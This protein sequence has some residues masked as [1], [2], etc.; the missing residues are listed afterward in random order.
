MNRLIQHLL[1]VLLFAWLVPGAEGAVYRCPGPQ[2]HPLFQDHPCTGTAAPAAAPAPAATGGKHFLWR[3]EGKQ[4]SAWLLGSLHFGTPALYPL[5]APVTAAYEGS[6]ALV[7]EADILSG[8]GQSALLEVAQQGSYLDGTT[9]R[10]HL[11][12][13]TWNALER[14]TRRHQLPTELIALQ[15]PWL[16]ALTVLGVALRGA[17]F[18]ETLGI[19]RHFLQQARGR[20]PILELESVGG[21]M[22]L[23]ADFSEAEQEEMLRQSL[24]E[25]DEG[26]D[27]FRRLISAWRQGDT[28]TVERLVREDFTDDGALGEAMKER[29]FTARNISM[30]DSIQALLEKGGG[31][32]FVVIGAGHLVGEDSVV[33][34]LR[35]RGYTVTRH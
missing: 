12:P 1:T 29:L 31:P 5:P 2:G 21:Q 30:S 16:A 25:G 20:K 19:D 23:F 17:G 28:L 3:V 26:T 6:S 7:V 9:L 18:D 24:A 27:Y 35:Q 22:Q 34:R 15:R 33:A 8:K 14:F 4:G 11:Q 13:A 10:D 32:Y